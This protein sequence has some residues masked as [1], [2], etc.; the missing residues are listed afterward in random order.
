MI[1]ERHLWAAVLDQAIE[2]LTDRRIRDEVNVKAWFT[3]NEYVPGSFL[4]ICDQLDLDASTIRRRVLE[5][6][7]Q[8]T[9]VSRARTACS[10]I[11]PVWQSENYPRV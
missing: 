9:L 2:D 11:L 4:W 10:A 5:I 1:S 8:R 7:E 3:S 6:P